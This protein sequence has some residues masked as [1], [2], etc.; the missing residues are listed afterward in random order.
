MKKSTKC[1]WVIWYHQHYFF[2][3]L[4]FLECWNFLLL[5]LLLVWQ[6]IEKFQI[7]SEELEEKFRTFCLFITLFCILPVKKIQ[8]KIQ[9]Y[10]F[11]DKKKFQKESFTY[12]SQYLG[13]R[14]LKFCDRGGRGSKIPF[15]MD[16]IS[17]RPQTSQQKFTPNNFFTCLIFPSFLVLFSACWQTF[18]AI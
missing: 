15:F 5:L 2:I 17:K 11:H 12:D 1:L 4:V 10:Y 13:D 16:V 8:T 3:S 7:Y 18:S 14:N 6:L 9:N